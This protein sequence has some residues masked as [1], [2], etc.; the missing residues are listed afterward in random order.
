MKRHDHGVPLLRF[1]CLHIYKTPY[2]TERTFSCV[3]EAM[4]ADL[5]LMVAD[6][7]LMSDRRRKVG[8]IVYSHAIEQ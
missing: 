1:L 8:S 2:G 3:V 4:A 7:R 6:R 5:A